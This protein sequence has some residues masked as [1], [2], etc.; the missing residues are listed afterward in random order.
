MSIHMRASL[1]ENLFLYFGLEFGLIVSLR[2]MAHHTDRETAARR[3]PYFSI[4]MSLHLRY[5]T[6]QT[7]PTMVAASIPAR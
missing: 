7:V 3:L 5:R 1:S 6:N 4:P 2:V